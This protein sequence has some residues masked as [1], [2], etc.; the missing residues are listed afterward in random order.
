M[1]SKVSVVCNT[2]NVLIIFTTNTENVNSVMIKE[3]LNV[4]MKRKK[5]SNQRKI[6][7]EKI[8]MY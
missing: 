7:Y 6:N 2:E 5:L 4:T 1:E 8:E 3:I